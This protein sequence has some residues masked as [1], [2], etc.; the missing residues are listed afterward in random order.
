MT[1]D[2]RNGVYPVGTK[3]PSGKDL[4]ARFGVSQPVTREGTERL[5]SNGLMDSWRGAGGMRAARE[6]GA[7]TDANDDP[8]AAIFR[9]L[10]DNL[11][12]PALAGELDIAF[13]VAIA[14]ATH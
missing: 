5:R 11:Y 13:H 10:A 7:Q 4:A 1:G 14:E 8:L 2:I 3:L 12:S 9:S 6:A